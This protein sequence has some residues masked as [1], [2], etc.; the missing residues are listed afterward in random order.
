MCDIKCPFDTKGELGRI[1][2]ES[3]ECACKGL[4]YKIV[5]WKKCAFES[6]GLY[7]MSSLDED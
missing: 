7:E 1:D 3:P 6:L 4:F 2:F 5:Y